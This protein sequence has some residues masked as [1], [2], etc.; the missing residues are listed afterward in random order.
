M[1]ILFDAGADGTALLGNMHTLGI[2][3]AL[4]DHVVISHDHSDHTGGLE[5]F[6]E[7]RP[8]KCYVPSSCHEPRGAE[9]VVRIAEATE[10]YGGVFTTGELR[11]V[12]QSLVLDTG[13][14][15]AVIVGC[16]HPGVGTILD[17]ARNFGKPRALIG[18]LHGFAELD[19]LKGLEVV[20]ATHC[21]QRAAEIQT[22]Y[23]D[24]AVEGGAGT[25]LEL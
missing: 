18:G 24:T 22:A 17:A 7:R 20:C 9:D 12:E 1:R 4:V 14:G 10:L 15:V 13:N 11:G 21:T 6:L 19:L 23:P 5:E 3:P 8:V 25:T 16:S 2:E